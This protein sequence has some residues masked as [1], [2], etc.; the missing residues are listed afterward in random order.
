MVFKEYTE[1][2]DRA[3]RM[4]NHLTTRLVAMDAVA[5]AN[6][7]CNEPRLCRLSLPLFIAI[8]LAFCPRLAAVPLGLHGDVG[9][10][11]C[12]ADG[13][14]PIRNRAVLRKGHLTIIASSPKRMIG[15]HG[16]EST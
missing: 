5:P 1:V 12:G 11:A 8:T 9:K 3:C 13:G 14:Y 15:N 4:V 2:K 7:H 16:T 6:R 10:G